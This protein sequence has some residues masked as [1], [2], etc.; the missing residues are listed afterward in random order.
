MY[1]PNCMRESVVSRQISGRFPMSHVDLGFCREGGLRSHVDLGTIGLTGPRSQD[2]M[3]QN[4]RWYTALLPTPFS[5]PGTVV[6]V[7]ET[8]YNRRDRPGEG[9]RP[10]NALRTP[11]RRHVS[12]SAALPPK[13][14]KSWAGRSCTC[15]GRVWNVPGPKIGRFARDKKALAATGHRRCRGGLRPGQHGTRHGSQQGVE[16]MTRR[17]R[18]LWYNSCRSRGTFG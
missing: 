12:K 2:D 3:G 8:P 17:S 6:L 9:G 1:V 18:T 10:V 14:H 11:P 4:P 15:P 16:E 7:W 5:L 13:T